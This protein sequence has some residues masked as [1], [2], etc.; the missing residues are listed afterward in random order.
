MSQKPNEPLRGDAAW[1]AQRDEI[2]KRNEAVY[3]RA[4]KER[5]A[6]DVD[7][8]KKR[9]QDERREADSLPEQPRP[10]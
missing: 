2:A 9:R 5:G 7:A 4:Q 8:A 1:R 6:R 10:L 3:A